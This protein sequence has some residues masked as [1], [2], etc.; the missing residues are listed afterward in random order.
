MI[1]EITLT[2]LTILMLNQQK[3]RKNAKV[4]SKG[5]PFRRYEV[6]LIRKLGYDGWRDLKDTDRR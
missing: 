5:C 1:T 4:R 2:Y 6:L 3:I